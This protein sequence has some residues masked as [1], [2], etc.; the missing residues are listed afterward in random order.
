MPWDSNAYACLALA[1][2]WVPTYSHVP[3]DFPKKTECHLPVP[4]KELSTKETWRKTIVCGGK[5]ETR[6]ETD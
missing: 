4:T 6:E 3:S 1:C 2:L 5:R